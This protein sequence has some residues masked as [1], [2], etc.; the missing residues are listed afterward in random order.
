MIQ[1]IDN[2]INV[3]TVFGARYEAEQSVSTNMASMTVCFLE[4]TGTVS[5]CLRAVL[6][7]VRWRQI[8]NVLKV[9]SFPV[10]LVQNMH[11]SKK[12]IVK[13][14]VRYFCRS[15][16]IFG[17]DSI[18]SIS[19]YPRN[20][21]AKRKLQGLDKNSMM[22]V[23]LILLSFLNFFYELIS[24]MPRRKNTRFNVAQS[25]LSNSVL[26]LCEGFIFRIFENVVRQHC[27]QVVGVHVQGGL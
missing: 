2:P 19:T 23:F 15:Y 17:P 9:H 13:E 7:F 27:R 18:L 5:K 26:V 1:L 6:G 20:F 22:F 24:R 12:E 14:K 16:R 11:I 4:K 21:A 25:F 10:I 8:S 3:T